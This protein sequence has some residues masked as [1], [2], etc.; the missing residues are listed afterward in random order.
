V[1]VG[2]ES[3]AFGISVAAAGQIHVAISASLALLL[4]I[5]RAISPTSSQRKSTSPIPQTG[6]AFVDSKKQVR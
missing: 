3:F 1:A 2:F 4:S 5:G 6:R